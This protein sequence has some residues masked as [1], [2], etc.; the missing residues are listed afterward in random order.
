MTY[1][2]FWIIPQK[3]E[4]TCEEV[5]YEDQLAWQFLRPSVELDGVLRELQGAGVQNSTAY[6]W[7]KQYNWITF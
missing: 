7:I 5:Q 3:V 2:N 1:L 6:S 4:L